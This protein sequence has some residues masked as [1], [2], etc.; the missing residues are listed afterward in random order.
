MGMSE[1]YGATDEAES[2]DTINRALDLGIDFFDASDAYGL[3][4]DEELVGRVL[5]P[6]RQNVIIATKFGIVRSLSDPNVRSISGRP[7][8]VRSAC[9]ASLKRLATDYIDLYYQHR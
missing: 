3:F 1:F 4:E 2:T 8:Y 7:E 6:H 9:D 5:G